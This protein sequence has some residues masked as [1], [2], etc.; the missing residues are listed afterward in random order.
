[1][2]IERYKEMLERDMVFFKEKH[3]TLNIRELKVGSR[4]VLFAYNEKSRPFTVIGIHFDIFDR[5]CIDVKYENDGIVHT[6]YENDGTTEWY[7]RV[8]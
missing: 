2:A 5:Y 8:E 1:M 7:E 3:E 4:Y 6:Y